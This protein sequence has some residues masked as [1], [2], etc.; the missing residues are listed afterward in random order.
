M[1]A[2]WAMVV[3]ALAGLVFQA[4]IGW[5]FL[6]SARKRVEEV[7][8]KVHRQGNIIT[9]HQMLLEVHERELSKAN[10]RPVIEMRVSDPGSGD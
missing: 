9:A 5:A 10:S 3:I 4:G 6:L 1:D 2:T 8:R 7:A